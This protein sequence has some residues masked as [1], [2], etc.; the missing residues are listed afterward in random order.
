M[1]KREYS[2]YDDLVLVTGLKKSDDVL[3]IGDNLSF[4]WIGN[5]VR[6]VSYVSDVKSLNRLIGQGRTFDRIIMARENVLA[7]SLVLKAA[8]LNKLGGV[9]C[10]FSEDD[11]LR[12]GFTKFVGIE[13]PAAAVWSVYSNVGPLVMTDANGNPVGME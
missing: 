4:P 8:Q 5:F 13:Y 12:E 2:F 7:G 11:V 9:I 3:F 6:S 1:G 10:F